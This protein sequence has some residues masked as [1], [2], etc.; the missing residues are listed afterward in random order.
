MNVRFRPLHGAALV[1][2]APLLLAPVLAGV[3]PFPFHRVFSRI[4][5]L[6]ALAVLVAAGAFRAE[7]RARVGLAVRPGWATNLITGFLLGAVTLLAYYAIAVVWGPVL[8][9]PRHQSVGLWAWKLSGTLATAVAVASAEEY[10]F[11]GLLFTWIRDA[12]S[13]R[14][15]VPWPA[16]AAAASGFALLHFSAFQPADVAGSSGVLDGVRLLMSPLRALVGPAPPWHAL[17]S[18]FL[19][20]LALSVAVLRAGTLFVAIGLHAGVV[21]VMR[22]A[23]MFVRYPEAVDPWWGSLRVY[24]GFLGWA[25]MLGLLVV[26]LAWPSADRRARVR[27]ATAPT[28]R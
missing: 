20:G 8:W 5:L 3:L 17:L 13:V 19:F 16:A 2:L 26:T 6:S 15:Q 4:L 22:A 1:L 10:L 25:V 14:F 9:T 12:W 7:A 11:R 21:F 28:G 18:L 27:A 23:R 24:D